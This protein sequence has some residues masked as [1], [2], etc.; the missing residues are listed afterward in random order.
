MTLLTSIQDAMTLCGLESPTS[1]YGSSDP[2]VAQFV[3]FAQV[4]GD[5]LSRFHDWRKLKVAG[6]ITGDGTTTLWDLPDDFDRLVGGL[7]FWSEESPGE[8]LIGPVLDDELIAMKAMLTDPPEPV[9]RLNGDDI[10]IWPALDSGEV[11]RYEY[12]SDEWIL[13]N[14]GTTT[15]ARWGADTDTAK[16]P[17]RIL[18]LGVVWR[19]KQ[20]KGLDYGEAFRS[21]QFERVRAASK[22]GGQGVI[23][24]SETGPND[25]ARMGRLAI[26]RVET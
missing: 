1:A 12:R 21:Y 16:V 5:E 23:K 2:T 4:E 26:Y 3:A 20:A 13:D 18:T 9:W 8:Q 24:L 15:K 22:D 19:W 6:T 10:E 25:I 17:E 11:V 7:A 14:N